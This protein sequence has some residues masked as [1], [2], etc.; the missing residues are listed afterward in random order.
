MHVPMRKA[1]VLSV[2][3]SLPLHFQTPLLYVQML[4]L[5]PD[6]LL[7]QAVRKIPVYPAPVFLH[8]RP[9]LSSVLLSVIFHI[10][11]WLHRR[12]DPFADWIYITSDIHISL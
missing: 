5:L 6:V 1:Y 4:P 2:L 7:L 10:A 3:L 8:A 11:L 9:A 12:Q